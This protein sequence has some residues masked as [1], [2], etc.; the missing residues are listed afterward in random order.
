MKGVVE[1]FF[2]KV[3]MKD[4]VSYDSKSG[5]TFLHP[6]RQANIIYDG[7]VVGY[8]G[9]LHPL[10]GINYDIKT[11]VYIAV[12]DMEMIYSKTSFDRKY[13]GIAKYPA[14]SRDISMVAKKEILVGEIEEVIRKRGGKLLEGYKLFD[15]YEGEQI[16][17][18]FKSVAYSI[19][20][21]ASDRTLSDEEVNKV[22]DKIL[23]GLKDLG[24]E[25]RG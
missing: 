3:G 23:N 6:G 8:I 16:E 24:I 14:V 12:I 11:R 20:F 17:K 4:I 18:G 15:V 2:E 19:T 5:K 13:V 7:D 1:E 10:V 22:M 25:L 9:E 21:R